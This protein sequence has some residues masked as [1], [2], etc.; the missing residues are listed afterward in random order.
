MSMSPAT[1]HVYDYG[2]HQVLSLPHTST[3]GFP[4]MDRTLA[5]YLTTESENLQRLPFGIPPSTRD[6]KGPSR[7]LHAQPL[8]WGRLLRLPT[9]LLLSLSFQPLLNWL[10][11]TCFHLMKPLWPLPTISALSAIFYFLYEISLGKNTRWRLSRGRQGE[12][13]LRVPTKITRKHSVD[14]NSSF[15][16]PHS[17]LSRIE[18]HIIP[19]RIYT[20]FWSRG[21]RGG[22]LVVGGRTRCWKIGDGM[23]IGTAMCH[24][25]ELG[26]EN[27]SSHKTDHHLICQYIHHL[28]IYHE[29]Q[30][31]ESYWIYVGGMLEQQKTFDKKNTWS[32]VI[33]IKK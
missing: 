10:F 8:C 33:S 15:L 25:P 31:Q 9:Y 28:Y 17:F 5:V 27:D 3:S 13:H 2:K 26:S 22:C 14:T 4:S 30:S 21:T 18:L 1:Q 11:H 7:S 12:R 20:I 16:S 6:R 23:K 29:P 32:L 24:R 19:T